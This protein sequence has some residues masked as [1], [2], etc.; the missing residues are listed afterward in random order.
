MTRE[1]D[2]V[3][4]DNF[5][6]STD[7]KGKQRSSC[8]HCSKTYAPN[9]SRQREHILE[10]CKE[11]PPSVKLRYLS[12]GQFAVPS[13]SSSSRATDAEDIDDPAI[14]GHGPSTGGGSSQ[15]QRRS[16]SP[17]PSTSSMDSVTPRNQRARSVS[18]ERFVDYCGALEKKRLDT[19][20]AQGVYASGMALS[21]FES[22][23]WTNFFTMLRPSYKVPSRYMLSKPL[24]QAEYNSCTA[25]N[26]KQIDNAPALGIMTDSYTNTRHESVINIIVTTPRPVLFKQ[27]FRGVERETGVYVGDHL[28]AVIRQI[29][30]DKFWI[31]IT[32]NAANMQVAWQVVTTEFPHITA[33]GC[34]S[35]CWDLL[36]KDLIEAMSVVLKYYKHA[37]N[38]V[39]KVKVSSNILAVFTEKQKERYGNVCIS[40]KLPAKT[41]WAG[42]VIL[43]NS[44][45]KNRAAL[46]ETVI[47]E[48]VDVDRTVRKT[49]LS[50]KFWD[51][52]KTISD[53]LTPLHAA[54]TLIEGNQALLSDVYFLHKKINDAV[55]SNMPK[56]RLTSDEKRDVREILQGR[57]EFTIAP[58]HMAAYMLDPRF[59]GE[60]LANE[61]VAEAI[62]W[63][64]RMAGHRGL[65]E[66][67][68]IA[69]LGQFRTKVGFFAN[70]SIFDASKNLHPAVWWR[71]VCSTEPISGLAASLLSMP[72]SAAECERRWSDHGFI[73]DKR[74]NHLLNTRVTKLTTTRATLVAAVTKNKELKPLSV[75]EMAAYFDKYLDVESRTSA[76]RG[77]GDGGARADEAEEEELSDDET[78][79]EEEGEEEET[80]WEM[81]T[82]SETDLDEDEAEEDDPSVVRRSP[83]RPR[84]RQ[85][86]TTPTPPP[87]PAPTRA[88]R[89]AT[90]SNSG[91]ARSTRASKRKHT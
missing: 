74:R 86:P 72:P 62:T 10:K 20:F 56:L 50:N 41:R 6:L 73:H 25:S 23:Y 35:H 87:P 5:V 84:P 51:R 40:L 89:C 32:D 31:L 48:N 11:V 46:Q 38:V 27:I 24:L 78:D 17:T 4:Q 90:A 63:I 54:I 60:G 34:A 15:S 83:P 39:R 61:E 65:D 66:G 88:T 16:S 67:A 80:E 1:K 57:K 9:A 69:N 29:G 8:K 68:V 2:V 75:L 45:L 70:E 19:A 59:M 91:A 55:I 30:P 53:M 43:F 58:I 85:P 13:T 81:D 36:F 79:E 18:M 49:V 14:G 26:Q 37:R 3:V 33:I 82:G 77:Q 44:L 76:H 64:S 21:A 28:V 22:P 42:A 71:G 47:S 7:E 12:S 52:I